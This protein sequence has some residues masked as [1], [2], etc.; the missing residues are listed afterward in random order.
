MEGASVAAVSNRQSRGSKGLQA[1]KQVYLRSR[2]RPRPRSR[3]EHGT[4][5]VTRATAGTGHWRP[6]HQAQV[7]ESK[8]SPVRGRTHAPNRPKEEWG[9]I[10]T[11]TGPCR[12][13]LPQLQSFLQRRTGRN[14]GHLAAREQSRK[15]EGIP[16]RPGRL[17]GL[18]GTPRTPNGNRG[19][20]QSS[21][22]IPGRLQV[23]TYTL[24]LPWLTP[25]FHPLLPQLTGANVT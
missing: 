2:T 24:S 8:A 10:Q 4:G 9:L 15:P 23:V 1:N 22:G 11:W 6:L 25:V 12:G 21:E 3:P 19:S 16:E 20:R 5:A 7:R 18:P 17:S 13:R 14:R